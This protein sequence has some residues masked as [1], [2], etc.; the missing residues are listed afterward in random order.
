MSVITVMRNA[1]LLVETCIGVKPGERVTV[2]TDWTNRAYG[3]A[4]AA[5]ADQA[6]ADVIVI[7]VSQQ[8]VAALG[9][10]EVEDPPE[11]LAAAMRE[12]NVNVIITDQEFSQRFSHRLRRFAP[13]SEDCSHYQVDAGMDEWWLRPEDL[14][15]MKDRAERIMSAVNNSERVRVTTPA[16][17]NI[18]TS[19][20]NR[21]CALVTP[22]PDRGSVNAANSI[23]LWGEANWAPISELTHGTVVVDGIMMGS[24]PAVKTVDDPITWT[25]ENGSVVKIEGG[26]ESERLRETVDRFGDCARVIAELGIGA[27]EKA[28]FGTMEEKACLGTVHFAIGDSTVFPGGTNECDTHLDGTMRDVTIEVDGKEILREGEMLI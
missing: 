28:R 7:D 10:G 13:V 5:A 8:V 23:P 21:G 1:R 26:E 6:G 12:A 9:S 20:G 4:V 25:V 2:L 11:Q 17:T 15:T 18:E 16:G 24:G 22:I 19:V 14:L 3:D 27:S